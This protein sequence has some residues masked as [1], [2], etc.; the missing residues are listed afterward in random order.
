MSE[1][2][3]AK[4][5]DSESIQKQ[6]LDNQAKIKKIELSSKMILA[7]ITKAF[8]NNASSYFAKTMIKDALDHLNEADKIG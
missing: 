5:K 7:N 8:N 2:E 4:H 3:I 1:L 6:K